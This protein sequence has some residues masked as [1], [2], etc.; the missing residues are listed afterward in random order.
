[1]SVKRVMKG[2]AMGAALGA[3]AGI[4]FAPRPGK[5]SQKMLAGKAHEVKG[6]VMAKAMELKKLSEAAYEKL[7]EEA[8]V[9]AKQ[10]KMTQRQIN[11]L[12]KDLMARYKDLKKK[13]G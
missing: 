2:F 7:V 6:M 4:L 11:D 9:Y 1:M 3:I 8:V 5:Q 13:I 12:K 10:K